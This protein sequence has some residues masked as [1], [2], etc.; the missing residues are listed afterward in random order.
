VATAALDPGQHTF[1]AVAK[2]NNGAT[3]LPVARAVTV[4]NVAPSALSA[5][6]GLVVAAN[7]ATTERNDADTGLG[8]ALKDDRTP[9]L[10][11]PVIADGKATL[12]DGVASDDEDLADRGQLGGATVEGPATDTSECLSTQ[13]AA[14]LE[15]LEEPWLSD[16]APSL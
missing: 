9:R 2:D 13:E 8:M 14:L 3:S 12:A 6:A 15:S 7:L 4:K 5:S 11:T 1:Y 10:M 16:W